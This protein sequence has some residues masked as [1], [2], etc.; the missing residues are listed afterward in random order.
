MLMAVKNRQTPGYARGGRNFLYVKDAAVAVVNALTMGRT[1][2]CYILGNEN[3]CFK[4]I[5]YKM[6][7][8]AGVAPPRLYVPGF[9]SR[10]FGLVMTGAAM[11]FGFTPVLTYRTARISEDFNYY[12]AEKAIRELKLPQTPVE[13]G[14][15]DAYD[16]LEAIGKSDNHAG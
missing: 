10:F 3:L 4:E 2:E 13:V 16:W 1:G 6:A 12:S 8:V 11:I 5:F 15:K 9:A 7:D 14:I